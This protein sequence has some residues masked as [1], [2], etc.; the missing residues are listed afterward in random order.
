MLFSVVDRFRFMVLSVCECLVVVV[1]RVCVI[2]VWCVDVVMNRLLSRYI[3]VVC[4]E[5]N[6]G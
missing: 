1:S 6:S 4:I 5:E 3:C 2:L